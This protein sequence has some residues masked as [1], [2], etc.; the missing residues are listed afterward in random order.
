[1][2]E[3]PL[4]GLLCK[5]AFEIKAGSLRTLLANARRLTA[6]CP[7][8]IEFRAANAPA[9]HHLDGLERGRVYREDTLDADTA[10]D[11]THRERLA[12]AAALAGDADAFEG[13]NAFFF[14]FTN[15]HVDT[16]CV[17]R[18]ELRNA[19]TQLFSAYLFH[20]IHRSSV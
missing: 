11:L 10:G 8:I 15:A 13:L 17:A 7:Q 4:T 2:H 12:H 5:R 19:L 14:T 20:D 9:A 6:E 18:A 1:M 3:S 16:Q